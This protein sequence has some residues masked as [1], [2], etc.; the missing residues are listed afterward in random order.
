MLD[1][2]LAGGTSFDESEELLAFR[3]RLLMAMI[4]AA[5]VFAALFV[6]LDWMGVN[7]LGP[8]Q[9]LATELLAVTTLVLLAVLYGRKQAFTLVSVLFIGANFFAY[10]SALLFM[11]N[12]EM[13]VI[14]FYLLVVVTYILHGRWPGM[15]V[16]VLVLAVLVVANPYMQQPFSVN[17]LFTTLISLSVTSLISATYTSRA[18]SFFDRM[19][20]SVAQLR[21]L[22]SRDP[23]TGVLNVRAYYDMVSRIVQL[24]LRTGEHYA[25]LF[26]DIDHFKR[27]NDQ[28]GHEVGDR[29]LQQVAACLSSQL[30]G[31]DVLGRVGGEEF[32]IVLPATQLDGAM[33]LAEKLRLTIEAL[34]PRV[35]VLEIPLTVS[36]GVAQQQGDEEL[37][38]VQ[39]RADKAM[40]HAKAGGRNCVV[41]IDRHWQQ[42]TMELPA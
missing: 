39:R 27:I 20:G 10:L 31:S 1:K 18:Q 36:V 13:R 29:V 19:M 11:V 17:G 22:A 38:E 8:R 28:Y 42:L 15:V 40:Y 24:A 41:T 34:K 23:L 30:R 35:G 16:S 5:I 26:V 3:F 4:W 33:Q 7:S 32:A 21:E 25:L 2:I 37:V 9:L 12:D 14:W 6:A